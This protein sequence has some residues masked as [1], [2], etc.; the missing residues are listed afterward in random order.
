MPKPRNTRARKVISKL[1]QIRHQQARK[2]DILCNDMVAAHT[3][4]VT[5]L[6]DLHFGLN[7]YQDLIG[8]TD[9]FELYL[10]VG[11]SLRRTIS[12]LNLAVYLKETDKFESH[13]LDE[14]C[15]DAI[16]SARLET[17]FTPEIRE[18][19]CRSNT[20]FDFH[21]LII[22]SEQDAELFNKISGALIPLGKLADSIGFFF[23]YKYDCAP[24]T[25]QEIRRLTAISPGLVRAVRA[26]LEAGHLANSES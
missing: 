3:D 18:K 10:L 19:I 21:D 23:A 4:F 25:V 24:L 17:C 16:D 12:R 2:I 7:F 11:T 22:P 1:N 8:V 13:S 6:R 14:S 20:V 15:R 5:Q 9:L 26:A